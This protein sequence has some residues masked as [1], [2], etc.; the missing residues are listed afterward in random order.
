MS[1]LDDMA[2]S[3]RIQREAEAVE[4]ILNY[5]STR[6]WLWFGSEVLVLEVDNTPN[7]SS[8]ST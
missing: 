3:V 6:Q 1:R 4:T 2:T 7:L 5:C 8:V